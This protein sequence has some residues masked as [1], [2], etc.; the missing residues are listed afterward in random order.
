VIERPLPDG[1]VWLRV[2]KPSYA[3]PFDMSYA[4]EQGGRWNPPRSWPTLYVNEDMP[5]VHAQVLHMFLDRGIH[6]DDIDDDAPILLAAAVLPEGQQVADVI[7]E[8]GV[9]GE[10]GGVGDGDVV[11][12]ESGELGEGGPVEHAE[13][14]GCAAVHGGQVG[15]ARG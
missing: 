1:H 11:A 13:D 3:D 7:S 12:E 2:V 4:Q 6:P 9:E 14:V 10:L 5:T 8:A 15:D